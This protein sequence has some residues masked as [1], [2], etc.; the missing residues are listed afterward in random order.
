LFAFFRSEISYRLMRG[1]L[2][3]TGPQS[4]IPKLLRELPIPLA[5]AADRARIAETVRGA[6]KKRDRADILEDKALA[7]LTTAIEEATG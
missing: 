6:Y 4:I 5:P 3:G 1:M 7:L 2:A